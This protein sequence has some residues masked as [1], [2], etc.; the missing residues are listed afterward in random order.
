MNNNIVLSRRQLGQRARREHEKAEVAQG[1]RPCIESLPVI[2]EYNEVLAKQNLADIDSGASYM[3]NIVQ[4]EATTSAFIGIPNIGVNISG[5]SFAAIP[6]E[7]LSRHYSN[8]KIV[9]KYI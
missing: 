9:T 2:M 8:L 4:S 7:P 1:K 5:P 3:T 6:E